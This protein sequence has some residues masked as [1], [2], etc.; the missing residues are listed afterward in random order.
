MGTQLRLTWMIHDV[1]P[2][3]LD[4]VTIDGADVWVETTVDESGGGNL[5]ETA[6]VRHRPKDADLLV[7][8]LTT[9]GVYGPATATARPTPT[10]AAPVVTGPAAAVAASAPGGEPA[11]TGPPWAAALAGALMLGLGVVLGRRARRAGRP[12]PSPGR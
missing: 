10:A 8:T 2:W 3:R 7:E 9:L 4:A 11:R 5:F 12:S 1:N 6:G